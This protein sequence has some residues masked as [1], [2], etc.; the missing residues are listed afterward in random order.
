MSDTN[1]NDSVTNDSDTNDSP[2]TGPECYEDFKNKR[3]LT[4]YINIHLRINFPDP[5][6]GNVVD[7]RLPL[8]DQPLSGNIVVNLA[9]KFSC[10]SKQLYV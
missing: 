4:T 8:A 10:Y 1:D 6:G 7:K 2:Y 3:A 5:R 9:I